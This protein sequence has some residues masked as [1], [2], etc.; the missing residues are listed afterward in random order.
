MINIFLYL[1]IL[2]YSKSA[3]VFS[4]IQIHHQGKKISRCINVDTDILSDDSDEEA[5]DKPGD[6]DE[7]GFSKVTDK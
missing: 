3:N 5:S 4:I 2:I 1:V 7:V 6:F